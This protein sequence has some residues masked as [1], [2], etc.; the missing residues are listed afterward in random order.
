[1]SNILKDLSGINLIK[2]IGSF[3]DDSKK[4]SELQSQNDSFKKQLDGMQKAQNLQPS[5][6]PQTPGMKKGGM[7]KKSIDGC[8]VRGKTRA[9]CK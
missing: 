9:K 1:M 6:T 2:K 4:I 3:G 5:Q 7:V 8:A